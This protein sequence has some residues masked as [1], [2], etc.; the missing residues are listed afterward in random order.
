MGE[1]SENNSVGKFGNDEQVLQVINVLVNIVVS[2][3][4]FGWKYAF[5]SFGSDFAQFEYFFF[6]KFEAFLVFFVDYIWL[7]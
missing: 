3:L 4:P 7:R 1:A 2:S 6:E 5:S